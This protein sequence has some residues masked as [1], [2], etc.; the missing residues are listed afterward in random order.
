MTRRRARAPREPAGLPAG[1]V[2]RPMTGSDVETVVAL[3][4]VLFPGEAWS[5]ELIA[6]EVAASCAQVP[7]RRYLVVERDSP[8]GP[9]LLGYGGLWFGDGKGDADLLSIATVLAARRQGIASAMLTELVSTAREA[10]CRAVLL[11][12]RESNLAARSLYARHGFEPIGTR[13]RY[14][15]APLEDAVVMRLP[16]QP[17][18]QPGPVGAEHL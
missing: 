11:E 18:A 8:Q 12:V 5:R 6:S 3:E 10:G 14:Y 1:T 9:T 17:G 7:D 2:M 4:R 16:L 13:R 15:L